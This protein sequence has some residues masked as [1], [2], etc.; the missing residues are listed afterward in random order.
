MIHLYDGNNHVRRRIEADHTG[1]V[2]KNLY[3]D[4]I[5]SKNPIIY[6][7][8]GKGALAP[9]K[10]IYPAYKSKRSRTRDDIYATLTLFKKILDLSQAS[11]IE[12]PGFE[13]DDVIAHLVNEN[14]RMK[15][16]IHSND[17]DF[18]A[19]GM[20][21]DR[22]KFKVEPKYVRLYKTLV[23]DPSDSI[24][25]L[26]GFGQKAWD[27]ADHLQL[28]TWAHGGFMPFGNMIDSL[29]KSGQNWYRNENGLA[30]LQTFWE[31]IGFL[32]VPAKLIDKHTTTGVK[33]PEAAMKIMQE[34]MLW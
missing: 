3:L 34:F 30:K 28:L 33:S 12:V 16:H 6:V 27:Y 31:I 9:R 1:Q 10:A 21:M 17:A 29:P 4:V 26:K 24:P 18:A 5:T 22:E 15:F 23:G 8:D 13:A 20:P 2:L 7:W 14:S 25:G 11:Q 32:P 19:L